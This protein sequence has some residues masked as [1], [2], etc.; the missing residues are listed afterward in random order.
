MTT[1]DRRLVAEAIA[2]HLGRAGR[3][4]RWLSEHS[5]IAYS[6]LRRRMQGRSD[7]TITELADIALA[8]DLS[9]AALVPSPRDTSADS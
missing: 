3:S 7:F 6:T 5:G 2:A 4:R 1:E 8:L 9:P